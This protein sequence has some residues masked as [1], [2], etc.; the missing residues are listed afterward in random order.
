MSPGAQPSRLHS[1]I[2]TPTP[3][4]ANPGSA[5][6][7]GRSNPVHHRRATVQLTQRLA[8]AAVRQPPAPVQALAGVEVGASCS[9]PLSAAPRVSLPFTS[10]SPERAL[11]AGPRR[12][13][14]V[15]P[16][17]TPHPSR[18]REASTL[19][20]E[21]APVPRFRVDR[22]AASL[23]LS[24]HPVDP[25]LAGSSLWWAPLLPGGPAL[26]GFRPSSI[27]LVGASV[28]GV[29]LVHPSDP[30]ALRVLHR[31]RDAPL[32]GTPATPFATACAAADAVLHSPEPG[33]LSSVGVSL[34]SLRF[35]DRAIGTAPRSTRGNF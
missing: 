32:P 10:R 24:H 27:R 2:R 23:R 21:R 6:A 28:S 11:N 16:S 19:L 13:S 25:T 9:C 12:R 17:A 31:G 33:E 3:G 20:A 14:C 8:S 34:E 7:Q 4:F 22:G 26:L 5:D 35:G 15:E 29:R 18:G 30:E 1:A